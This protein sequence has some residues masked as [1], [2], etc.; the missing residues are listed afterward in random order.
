VDGSIRS[1]DGIDPHELYRFLTEDD[2]D[3]NE[4][5]GVE[6]TSKEEFLA[7]ECDVFIPAA[8]G[9]AIHKSNAD[10]LNCK[11]L[12]EGAN[13]PT[14]PAADEILHDKGIYIAP[15]VL[16]NAGGVIVSYFEWVQNLQ[17]F[18]WDE[19]EVNQRLEKI[20]KRGFAEVAEKCEADGTT[21]RIAAY[22]LGIGR[23][24]EASRTRGYIP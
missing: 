14:T 11:V 7:T 3:I 10:T 16:C 9:G 21:P 22:E 23:V 6:T 8:L 17:H 15:D 5:S 13:S 12:L 20:I 18:R 1:D 2:G 24:V 19:D 4:F